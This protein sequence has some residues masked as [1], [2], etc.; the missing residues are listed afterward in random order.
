MIKIKNSQIN[1]DTINLINYLL[2][3]E[4][5]SSVAFRLM[6]IVRDLTPIIDDKSKLETK[7]LEKWLDRDEDGNPI[8]P[9]DNNGN[10]IPDSFKV[11]DV[12]LFNKEMYEFMEIEHELIYEKIDFESLGLDKIKPIDLL[13]I[14]FLFS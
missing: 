4:L 5:P 10:P 13:K 2:D 3:K 7:I 9:L 8:K 11:K 6:K 1:T 14:E 12:S